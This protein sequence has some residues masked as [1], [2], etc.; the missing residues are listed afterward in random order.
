MLMKKILDIS[1]ENE[2]YVFEETGQTMRRGYVAFIIKYG[3]ENVSQIITFGKLQARAV[4]KDVGRVLGF[5]FAETD[6]ITK[7]FPDELGLTLA[8]AI[9]KEPRIQ[10]IMDTDPRIAKLIAYSL[11]LEG[12]YRNAGMHA[13][14]VIITEKPI[15]NYCPLYTGRDGDVVTQFDKDFSEAI[16][17]VK[18]DFLG[19]KTLTVIDNAVKLVRKVADKD[20]VDRQFSIEKIGYTDA[21]VFELV[22]SGDTDGVF[23]VES[24]GMKD[25]CSR[26]KPNSV[27]DL[28]AINA[29]YRP[30][31]LGSG[32]VDDFIERKHGRT[33][34]KYDLDI[35]AP[36]LKDTYGVI[37][38]QEQVMQIAR[39]LAGYSLGQADMLRRAM[40][41]KKIDEM[42]RHREIFVNGAKERKID[43][44][45]AEGIYNLMAK[46]AE[47]GFN[48]SHSAAYAVLTY[49][50]AYLKAY[51][52][53]EFMAALMTTEIDSTDKITKYIADARAHGIPVLPPDVN[54]SEKKF[55]VEILKPDDLGYPVDRRDGAPVKAIRFG[56]EA[57][58]GVGSIAVDVILESRD[59]PFDSVLN[60]CKRV[61]TRKV[62]KKVV[63]SLTLAGAFD[64]I[65]EVNRAS[66]FSSLEG[67][68]EHAG[69]EQAERE[70]G[71]ASL[72][73]A[74]NAGGREV[75]DSN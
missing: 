2:M 6:L 21:K 73:D 65:A 17:L 70:L 53:A 42:D 30:G 68:L 27:E 60:F 18:Y 25:L 54:Y 19:L 43:E 10:E 71:Q 34:I 22:S 13:A 74:F 66:L 15:V 62:N 50:T 52:P 67:L 31:P 11:K 4:V 28:T 58:K 46:F 64:S 72:F 57:V 9:E 49:Q 3:A 41:K 8:G 51:F 32:M 69:D 45:K 44:E 48:K 23:Q 26:I 20:S 35:L 38:Y 7:L 5:S 33:E 63:E 36:I 14:G 12:L 24:S 39:T 55:S 56:L 40:G 75:G 47:Y 61:S 59:Q 29:L 1:R 16:G 37:L